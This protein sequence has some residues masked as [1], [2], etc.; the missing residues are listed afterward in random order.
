MRMEIDAVAESL[1]GGHNTRTKLC[2]GSGLEVFEESLDSCLAKVPQK[3][4]L[5][6]EED[7][8]HLGDGKDH[9]TVGDIQDELLPH[10]LAPLLKALGMTRGTEAAGA[11]RKHK[12]A[13]FTAV[14]T[15]DAGKPAAGVA[16]VQIALNDLF[17]DGTEE[18][19]LLLK[20][21]LVLR[22]KA[23]EIVEKHSIEDR[24][25]KF[26]CHRDFNFNL[27]YGD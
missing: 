10:P 1:D 13:F 15:P 19:V 21:A 11:V 7:A 18:A 27:Y 23:V 24:T 4:A 5:V 8:Q 26:T 16:A 17:D 25:N 20:A 12:Q 6:A 22:E 2:A 14:R 9:L 3:P